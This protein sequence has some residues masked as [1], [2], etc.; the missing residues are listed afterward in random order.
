MVFSDL[1]PDILNI[2]LYNAVKWD[3]TLGQGVPV[4]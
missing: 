3:I 1:G 4:L 2:S